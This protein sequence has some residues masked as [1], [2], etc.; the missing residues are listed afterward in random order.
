M[1]AELPG[2]TG[3]ECPAR[4]ECEN[5]A[6]TS[7]ARRAV[8]A[9]VSLEYREFGAGK[10]VVLLHGSGPGA[11]GMSN[12]SSNVAALAQYFRVIVP[13]FPGFGGSDNAL[14]AGPI[15][16]SLARILIDF[17][18][19]LEIP[20]ASFVGN[21]LGGST[22]LC[23]AL[24]EPGRVERLVLMGPGG[25]L[26]G[27]TPVP[28]EGLQRLL[29][30]YEGGGPSMEKLAGF[31]SLAVHDRTS[32]TDDLLQQR[33]AASLRPDVVA[34]PPMRGRGVHPEDQLWRKPLF[35]VKQPTL[36]LWG[37]EDRIVPLDSAF[38]FLKALPNASLHVFPRCGHWVQ[39][40]RAHEFNQ[41]VSDFLLRT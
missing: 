7:V 17:L 40:E 14:P 23:I 20:K 32:I 15:F 1:T 38:P 10:P 36:L 3:C 24:Q 13:D 6:N 5:M 35:E 27:F 4:V 2:A 22:A 9:G 41:L 19:V 18:R 11:T 16:D 30:F 29:G 28:T 26:P 31:I 34:N 12:F 21:S 37:R 33:Y 25:G 8:A 39:W